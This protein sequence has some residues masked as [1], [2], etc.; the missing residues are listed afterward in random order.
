LVTIDRA[1]SR[2]R[3]AA[4]KLVASVVVGTAVAVPLTTLTHARFYLHVP[5]A[6]VPEVIAGLFPFGAFGA[7]LSRLHQAQ[8]QAPLQVDRTRLR[9]LLA[10]AGAAV[11][12]TLLEQLAR[13]LGTPVD[14]SSLSITSR[15]VALQ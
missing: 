10:T 15:G 6:S 1:L 8:E 11:G 7:V 13:N 12:F 5:R 9:Y 3:L 14:A 2:D 4:D